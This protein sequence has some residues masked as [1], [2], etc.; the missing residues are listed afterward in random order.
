MK[1]STTEL[2]CEKNPVSFASLQNVWKRV[3]T[4]K[5]N[6]THDVREWEAQQR[7][8]ADHR[9]QPDVIGSLKVTLAIM[10]TYCINSGV[11]CRTVAIMQ[12]EKTNR[13]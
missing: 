8:D 6:N 4:L 11:G 2:I 12:L 1:K 13:R 9:D 3:L 10:I 5:P 7:M